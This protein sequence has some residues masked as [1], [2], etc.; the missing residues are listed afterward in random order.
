M[1][2]KTLT[3]KLP[4]E[5]LVHLRYLFQDK[6]I[7]G[8]ELLKIYPKLSKVTIYRQVKKPLAD[9]NVDKKTSS[10][11]PKKNFT[12]RQAPNCSTNTHTSRALWVFH[13]KTIES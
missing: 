5:V 12:T 10:W 8:N 9:K 3:L 4:L 13:Y 2:K 7:R 1:K 11:Q 6:D